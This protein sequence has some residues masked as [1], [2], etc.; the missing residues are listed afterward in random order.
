MDLQ[1]E[2]PSVGFLHRWSVCSISKNSSS[3]KVFRYLD[4]EA[5]VIP[6]AL[7]V[8]SPNT[9]LTEQNVQKFIANQV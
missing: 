7:V 8:R 3:I 6:I 4:D 1:I 5:G 9:S 2:A